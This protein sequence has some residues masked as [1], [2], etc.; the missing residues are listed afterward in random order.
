MPG[1]FILNCSSSSAGLDSVLHFQKIEPT[2]EQGKKSKNYILKWQY[3]PTVY[4][5][6]VEVVIYIQLYYI[7]GGVV[8]IIINERV[9]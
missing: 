5:M 9:S 1:R 3:W 2:K 8:V 6:R 4:Y 7:M